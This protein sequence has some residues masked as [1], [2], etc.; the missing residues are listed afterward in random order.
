M[1]EEDLAKAAHGHA[2]GASLLELQD[3]GRKDK[4][5]TFSRL[6]FVL[7]A[8]VTLAA[9]ILTKRMIVGTMQLHEVH[10]VVGDYAR[11]TY[12]LNPG[13]AF[14]LFPGSRAALITVSIAAVAVVVVVGVARQTRIWTVLPLGLILGGALGNLIDRVRLGKVVDFIQVGIPPDLYWPVF[15]VAD[16][17]VTVGVCWLAL[18]LLRGKGRSEERFP[19]AARSPESS[20]SPE[21]NVAGVAPSRD[22]V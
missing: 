9:D 2:P 1:R 7:A 8:L 16:A 4:P 12:I 10:R 18:G 15:N 3:P 14:G 17:A 19:E 6:A 13:A 22:E 21:E 20:E 5:L 11:I